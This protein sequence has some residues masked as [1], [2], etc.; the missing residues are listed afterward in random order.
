MYP[1]GSIIAV[2]S[3]KTKHLIFLDAEIDKK[4]SCVALSNDGRYLATGHETDGV[5]KVEAIIWDLDRAVDTC[6]NGGET[7]QGD[8]VIHRLF[9]HRGKV[10]SLD[11]SCDASFLVTLGGQDDNDLIA[12]DVES[13][14]GICGSPAA[15]DTAYCV[16][17]LNQR[18]DR[19][20]TCGNYHFRVWQVCTETRKLHAVD[21]SMG[22]IRRVMKCL[23]I[24]KDDQFGFAGSKTGE[25]LKFRI[26]RDEIKRFEEPDDQ[27]PNLEGYNRERM[28]N[29]VTSVACVINPLSGNTNIIAGAGD[30]TVQLLNPNLRPISSH[31][32]KLDG[33]VTSIS[34]DQSSKSFIVGTELSQRYS[35]DVAHFTPELRGSCHYGE[36]F[37][38]KFPRGCSDLFATASHADIRVWDANQRQELL[39]IRVPNV[40]CNAIDITPSGT[41]IISAWSDK[42]IRSVFPQSGKSK[43]VIP[44]AHP[45]E[46]TALAHCNDD[47]T[48]TEWRLVSGGKEGG[49]RVWIITPTHQRLLYS[50]KEHRGSINALTCNVDGSQ[51]VS[52]SSDGSCI[53]WDLQNGVRIHALFESAVFN[54]M[55]F[56]PDESQYLTCGTNCKLTYWDAYDANTIRVT[57]G[58]D[59]SMTCLDI[60]SNGNIFVSGSADKQVKLWDYDDGLT[61]AIGRGH[62]G[63]INNVAISPDEKTLVSVGSEGG[64]FIWDLASSL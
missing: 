64:I 55:I 46:V 32:V 41:S 1:L 57:D 54:D 11:F 4:V 40:T 18:N 34:L 9:Q 53:V 13:G 50:M 52:A 25:V 22:S 36:I 19:F 26:D 37:D 27:R 45:D 60:K 7:R 10:Q 8:F 61:L 15:N 14:N 12:W 44:D 2:K 49:L 62:S 38:V 39:R 33:G 51:V 56:H 3:V 28:N 59:A 31:C 47:D 5:T 35:I 6:I 48:Q 42:K 20:V 30:G 24:S 17:W 21:A 23:S 63:V 16:K 43:F 29:G 58:G